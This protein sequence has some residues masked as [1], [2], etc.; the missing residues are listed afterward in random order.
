MSKS[1]KTQWQKVAIFILLFVIVIVISL[2]LWMLLI[3][4]LLGQQ[5]ALERLGAVFNKDTDFYA[6]FVLWVKYP[7][8]RHYIELLLDTPEYFVMFFNSIKQVALIL[9]GQL[10]I[11]MPAAWAFARYRFPGRRILFVVYTILM[12]LP[13]QVTMVSS[14]LVLD[15]MGLMNTLWAV[16]LPNIFAT[17]PVFIMTK[18]FQKIPKELIEAAR[19]DG[20]SELKL[21]LH[22]GIP[23][24][25]PGIL[26]AMVL[27]FMEYW[28][29]VE[30][31]LAFLQDKTLWPLSLYMSHISLENIGLAMVAAVISLMPA[32]LLFLSG[33]RYVEQGIMASG[34][35]E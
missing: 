26:S 8:L 22:L 25:T 10:L 15:K 17:F 7:T 21:F 19:L 30:Q 35:K 5:E 32:V 12:V 27:G 1:W 34:L 11:G 23:M 31:P 13:F 28:N 16:V 9:L 3:S 2:P 29:N 6:G 4:S 33:Q 18:F 20:A 24:G 14:Y